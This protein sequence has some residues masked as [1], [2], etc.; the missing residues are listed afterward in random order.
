MRATTITGKPKR[1]YISTSYVERQ[2]LT[3]RMHNRRFTRLTNAFSK[4]IE[5]H[6][7][8]IALHFMYYNFCK[9]HQTLRVTPAMESGLSDHVWEISELVSLLEQPEALAG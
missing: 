1:R 2:N 9:V 7:L 3:L 8:S 6:K 4:K 5:N